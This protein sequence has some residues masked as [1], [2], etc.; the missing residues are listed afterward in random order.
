MKKLLVVLAL[1]TLVPGVAAADTVLCPDP[2]A[3]Y[4]RQYF[5]D[6]A[7]GCVFGDGTLNGAANDAFLD[8][9]E[10]F[11]YDWSFVGSSEEWGAGF[12]PISGISITD[13]EALTFSWEIDPALWSTGLF[14]LGIKDGGDP[15]WAVFL[16]GGPSGTGG[17]INGGQLALGGSISHVAL[18]MTPTTQVPEPASMLLLGAGLIGLAGFVRRRR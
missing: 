9:I 17:M 16:L 5:V 13:R 14:A 3:G 2:A 6:P 11:G 4:T 1:L 7:L 12:E 8:L 18:Y 15:Q 10:P